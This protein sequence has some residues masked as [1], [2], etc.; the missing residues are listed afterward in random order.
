MRSTPDCVACPVDEAV[1]RLAEAGLSAVITDVTPG[2]ADRRYVQLRVIRQQAEAEGTIHLTVAAFIPSPVGEPPTISLDAAP[3]SGVYVLQVSVQSPLDLAVGAL[4]TIPFVPGCYLYVGSAKRGLRSRL[5]RHARAE[6]KQ[7]WH[8]DYLT[9]AVPPTRAYVWDWAAGR[10]CELACAIAAFGSAT[11]GFG[12][13]DCACGSH[14]VRL[15]FDRNGWWRQLGSLSPPT[16]I[17][18]LPEPLDG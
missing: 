8:V 11:A 9:S 18:S 13:S 1:Q 17:V 4:G 10:E 14:L 5:A 7:K 2:D 6:K 16:S 12:A 15:D 3:G